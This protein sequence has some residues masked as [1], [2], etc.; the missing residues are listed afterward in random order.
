MS[1]IIVRPVDITGLKL[2]LK[3]LATRRHGDIRPSSRRASL[4]ECFNVLPKTPSKPPRLALWY[5][6]AITGSTHLATADLPEEQV[7]YVRKAVGS[8]DA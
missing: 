8:W 4:D 3:L 5:N 7:D 1:T 2:K 6:D